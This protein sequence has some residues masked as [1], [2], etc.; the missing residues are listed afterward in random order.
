MKFPDTPEST[1]ARTLYSS[2]FSNIRRVPFPNILSNSKI[3]ILSLFYKPLR[4]R[5]FRF[6]NGYVSTIPY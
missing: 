5:L 1:M 6:F 2:I 3:S 4:N